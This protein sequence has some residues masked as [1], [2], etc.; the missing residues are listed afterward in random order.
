M[1]NLQKL[2]AITTTSNVKS[3]TA[4]LREKKRALFSSLTPSPA[5]SPQYH[6]KQQSGA[7][8]LGNMLFYN[9]AI[10]EAMKQS[11]APKQAASPHSADCE[12][13]ACQSLNFLT[14]IL[15]YFA[16]ELLQVRAE[17]AATQ[18]KAIRS[19]LP[20][21]NHRVLVFLQGPYLAQLIQ[22][23]LQLSQHRYTRQTDRKTYRPKDIVFTSLFPPM[24]VCVVLY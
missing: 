3:N 19:T 10:L 21:S 18:G 22:S 24:F 7:E 16:E 17:A 23:C 20:R 14:L 9:I 1:R 4:A 6:S 11:L 2:N 12:H 5:E 8:L 15:N 13:I